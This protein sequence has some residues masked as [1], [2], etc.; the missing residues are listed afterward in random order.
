MLRSSFRR[1]SALGDEDL[2]ALWRFRL[3]LINLKPTLTPEQ[4]FAAFAKDFRWP[5]FVWI[6]REDERVVGFFLQRGE[7][8]TFR[9]RRLLCLLPEYGFLAPH[10]RGHPVLPVA[11]VLITVLALARHPLRPKYVAASTYPPGYIAFRRVIRPFWT[12]GSTDLPAF[13]RALLLHL[14]QRVSGVSFRAEDGT[15]N[16]RTLPIA[17]REPGEGGSEDSSRL[18]ADYAAANPAWRQGRGLF[19][20]FPLDACLLARVVLHGAERF[21]RAILGPS[22]ARRRS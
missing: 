13:E 19:F 3:S 14:G 20:L 1:A 17:Q 10:L 2:R 16:M 8:L 9:G 18:Y 12:L 4:D 15:V 22:L 11:S 6:L 5:G 7:P 21:A